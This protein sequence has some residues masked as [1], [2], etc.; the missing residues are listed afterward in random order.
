MSGVT[1]TRRDGRLSSMRGSPPAAR[2]RIPVSSSSTRAPLIIIGSSGRNSWSVSSSRPL[3]H[4]T[5]TDPFLT[6]RFSNSSLRTASRLR[7]SL[8]FG[9][10]VRQCSS[11]SSKA[12][13]QR[14]RSTCSRSLDLGASTGDRRSDRT[15]SICALRSRYA[16]GASLATGVPN[17]AVSSCST[18]LSTVSSTVRTSSLESFVGLR[19]W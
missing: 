8:P 17:S 10:T 16:A 12:C 5:F 1:S 3:V 15:A 13:R 2:G 11:P 4:F 9:E 14:T 18:W 6:S 19:P 7:A